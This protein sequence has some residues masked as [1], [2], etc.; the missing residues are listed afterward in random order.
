MPQ[1]SWSLGRGTATISQCRVLRKPV[2]VL[3][4]SGLVMLVTAAQTDWPDRCKSNARGT[5]VNY[6][7][8]CTKCTLRDARPPGICKARNFRRK[9]VSDSD[10]ALAFF[11]SAALDRSHSTTQ[12]LLYKFFNV[13]IWEDPVGGR[14]LSGRSG[15]DLSCSEQNSL[16]ADIM[17]N[18]CHSTERGK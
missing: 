6:Q 7:P 17:V 8:G 16:E 13:G 11:S 9:Q 10:P 18:N 1:A 2:A 4:H 15:Q 14:S 5:W 12:P 3:S